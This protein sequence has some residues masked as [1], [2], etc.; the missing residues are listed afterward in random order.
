MIL[1]VMI[2]LSFIIPPL[3]PIFLIVGIFG[4]LFT[5]GKKTVVVKEE[6]IKEVKREYT[7]EELNELQKKFEKEWK[8]KQE[9]DELKR[10]IQELKEMIRQQNIKKED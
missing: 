2:I 1:I 8:E 6:K 3:F 9:R 10:E 4:V 7:E 5:S